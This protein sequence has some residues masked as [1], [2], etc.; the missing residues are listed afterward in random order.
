MQTAWAAILILSWIRVNMR[1]FNAANTSILAQY[2]VPG[3]HGVGR[4]E[5]FRSPI[6]CQ[7]Q[8]LGLGII[9]DWFYL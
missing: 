9:S 5:C 1:S 7:N 8:L 2:K 6:S 3:N 4:E